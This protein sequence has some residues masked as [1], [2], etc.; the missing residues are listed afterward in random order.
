MVTS[1][2]LTSQPC[3]PSISS[4][5]DS[6]ASPCR[7][8]GK[9]KATKTKGGSGRSSIAPF[10]KLTPDGSWLRMWSGFC[11]RRMD[12]S[13]EGYSEHWPQAG[14]MRSGELFQVERFENISEIEYFY[15]PTPTASAASTHP[16]DLVRFDCLAAFCRRL[17]G[18]GHPN[19]QFW[20]WLMM[21]PIGWTDL[22]ASE[23]L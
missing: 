10:A 9:G 13:L 15:W 20:E 3:L 2:K 19:P 17:Y 6:L 8:P 12:G 16:N 1:K 22:N 4:A 5:E 7:V 11:Q 18:K 14:M 21:F 23:T